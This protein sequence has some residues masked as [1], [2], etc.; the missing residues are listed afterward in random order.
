VITD[1]MEMEGVL[2]DGM[3][4]AG[5]CRLAL[6]AGNDM[7]LIS[8]TPSTQERTW[9]A[10]LAAVRSRGAF[11]SLLVDSVKRILETK[12]RAFRGASTASGSADVRLAVPA[13]GA[14]DFFAQVSARAVTLV[15]GTRVP[16]H[17]A[18]RERILLCGQFPEF[19]S[20][21]LKRYPAAQTF[22]FPFT[23]FYHAR[24]EDRAWV[25]SHALSFDTII[26]CVA[27]YNSLDVLQELQRLGG[28]V[29]V[30][31]ALSPVYLSELAWVRT[32]IAVYGDGRDSFRAGFSVLA[33]DFPATGVLPV[34][35]PPQGRQ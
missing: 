33:G 12:I 16:F 4:T 24:V 32:A 11:R 25:R 18:A 9:N 2:A 15:A 30:I 22:Q 35:F 7:V 17:P 19:L 3:D 6:E 1:D 31:S 28:R 8:H 21:G 26:F 34:N 14:K 29:I 13:P 5:A 20:E 23:P 10:L 27:D